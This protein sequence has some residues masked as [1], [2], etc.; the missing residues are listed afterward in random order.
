MSMKVIFT[1]AP[2]TGKTSCLNHFVQNNF[3]VFKEIARSVIENNII[4]KPTCVPWDDLAAFSEMVFKLQLQDYQQIT[5]GL[6]FYDR[7]PFDVFAY[8]HLGGLAIP[9][10]MLE[11]VKLLNYHPKVFLFPIWENIYQNDGARREGL[12][13]AYQIEV[14]LRKVYQQYHYQI[15]EVPNTSVQNRCNFILQHLT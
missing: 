11:A 13:K 14:N 6:T 12:Q 1:G 8:L 3:M 9:P 7:S 10:N 15:I 4:N 5:Q 2:S